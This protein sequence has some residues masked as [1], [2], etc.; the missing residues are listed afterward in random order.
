MAAIK[1][2]F[3]SIPQSALDQVSQKLSLA[4][5][6]D[7][8]HEAGWDYGAPLADIKRLTTYWREKYDWRKH[9]R[10]LNELPQFM[11][12]VKVDGFGELDIHFVHQTTSVKK[13]VPLLFVHGCRS[14][15]VFPV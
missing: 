7:E 3:I 13:A 6:P 10:E 5:F 4:T 14:E 9:E 2:Y 12:T 15:L 1:S 8:L 11:T